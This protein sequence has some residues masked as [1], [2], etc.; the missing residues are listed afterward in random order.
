LLFFAYITTVSENNEIK[1][2]MGTIIPCQSPDQNPHG[3]SDVKDE[4]SRGCAHPEKTIITK[5][6][7]K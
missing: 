7:K 1:K 5:A 4:T 6:R 2:L 3:V